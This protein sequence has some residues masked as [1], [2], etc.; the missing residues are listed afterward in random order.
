MVLRR[1][2]MAAKYC[3]TCEARLDE[4]LLPA[5]WHWSTHSLPLWLAGF[6]PVC[7]AMRQQAPGWPAWLGEKE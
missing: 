6:T 4:E 1:P 3:L 2:V 7:R 5:T